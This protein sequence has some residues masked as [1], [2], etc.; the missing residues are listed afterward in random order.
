MK[1]LKVFLISIVVIFFFNSTWALITKIDPTIY[2]DELIPAGINRMEKI[3]SD[4]NLEKNNQQRQA[5]VIKHVITTGAN[6]ANQ[7]YTFITIA[8]LEQITPKIAIDAILAPNPVELS[9][10]Q[11]TSLIRIA[12]LNNSPRTQKWMLDK[13]K[14]KFINIVLQKQ[15][16]KDGK[17]STLTSSEAKKLITWAIKNKRLD[18]ADHS[19][20]THWTH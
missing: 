7:Q 10:Q 13:K 2:E 6:E 19:M 12:N 3:Q 17:M 4:L 8:E 16:S 9:Q 11:V 18:P 14:K 15:N 20:K 5:L 1:G